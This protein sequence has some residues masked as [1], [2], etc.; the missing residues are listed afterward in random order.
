M[1]GEVQ[2][3]RKSVIDFRHLFPIR[4]ALRLDEPDQ[5][6]LVL[7]DGARDR[8]AA[9]HE[10][11]SNTPGVGWVKV[12]GRPEPARV[13]AFHLTDSHL[14]ELSAYITHGSPSV[15]RLDPGRPD[16]LKETGH[17]HTG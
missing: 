10:I 14:A 5:V 9:C 13:R 16:H 11:D 7:G 6:D 8:G 12:D 2:D 1:I 3:P 17:G 4:V 15:L